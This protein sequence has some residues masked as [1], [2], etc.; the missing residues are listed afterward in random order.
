MARE[1]GLGG[2][3]RQLAETA[4][5]LDRAQFEPHVGCFTDGGFRAKELREAG[6]PI[7]EL[8][9]RSLASG[10]A[11]AGAR[12]M[13]AYLGHHGIGLVHAFDVPL[14]LFAVPVAR[15][16]RTPVVLSSMRAHR[17]LTP[18][19]ARHLLRLTDRI[20]DGIV[21]NSRAVA[22][23]LAEDG[24]PPSMM[25]LAYNGLDTTRFRREGERAALPWGDAAVVIG[26]V[27]A[28]RPEK[29]LSILIE[30]FRKLKSARRGVKLVI[31]GS[32]PMLAELQAEGDADCH[33]EPAVGNVAPWLRAM[34][35]FVLPSLSEALS[36]SLMEAM[37]CGCC[38]V[39]SDTG[40]NPELVQDG[41]TGL[42]FPVGNAGALAARLGGL[43]D[44]PEYRLRLGVQAE[45]RMQQHFTREQAARAMGGIYQEF[46]ARG[47]S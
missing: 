12:R 23:E 29:G 35:I 4:L 42:L 18:G 43:L 31:V 1:L 16:Y 30:A 37:G 34:D 3:E 22:R 19:V 36:N 9:V 46:L 41:Q 47:S 45:R 6:V 40:G 15:F 17:D 32:G 11:V 20:V 10:S 24:V 25:R 33:F 27:C 21:V 28:L 7:L 39:A 13:G 14:D 44:E 8:G 5:A 26:I 2:T 38:V